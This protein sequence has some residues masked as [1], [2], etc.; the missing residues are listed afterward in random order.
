[1]ENDNNQEIYYQNGEPIDV[2]KTVEDPEKDKYV[3]PKPD[4]K[5]F[6]Y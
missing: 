4:F 3:D 1:M 6:V 5:Y 2:I